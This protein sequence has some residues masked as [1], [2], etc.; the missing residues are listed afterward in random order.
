M[1]FHSIIVHAS[2]LAKLVN[3]V[4]VVLLNVTFLFSTV[5]SGKVSCYTRNF[6]QLLKGNL[7]STVKNIGVPR[8]RI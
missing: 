8:M 5:S 2:F 3:I 7:K 1:N 6:H 4:Y